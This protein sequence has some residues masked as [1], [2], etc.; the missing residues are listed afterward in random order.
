MTES[1]I[2]PAFI[3]IQAPYPNPFNN[4]VTLDYKLFKESNVKIS[5]FDINGNL[6]K[7]LFHGRQNS[8]FQSIKWNATN[9]KGRVVSTGEY[10]AR[11]ELGN[12]TQIKKI[13]FVK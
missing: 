11:I 5:I 13:T 4:M 8:G 7:N 6:V 9:N 10:L 12:F 2:N 1:Y 3:E